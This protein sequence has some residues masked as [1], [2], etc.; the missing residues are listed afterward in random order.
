LKVEREELLRNLESMRREGY[1]Y[2]VKITAVDYV[3]HVD[4][5]YFLRN[6]VNGADVTLEVELKPSDLWVDTI[7]EQFAAADWYERELQE[8]FGVKIKGRHA[9]RLILEKWDGKAYPL[10]KSFEWGRDYEKL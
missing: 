8:M 1:L 3:E 4:V 10:R 9:P 2:L 6:I 5:V 7:I